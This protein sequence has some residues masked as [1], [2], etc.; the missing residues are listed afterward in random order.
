VL[1]IQH[2]ITIT[3]FADNTI[4]EMIIYTVQCAGS[5]ACSR[6][7]NIST[8]APFAGVCGAGLSCGAKCDV[9]SDCSLFSGC[10]LCTDGVYMAA[11]KELI[12]VLH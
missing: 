2:V 3:R 4:N 8:T 11:I 9:S 10:D 5:I 1:A 6:C 12:V 7:V